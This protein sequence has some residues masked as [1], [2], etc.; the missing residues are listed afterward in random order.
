MIETDGLCKVYASRTE[1]RV[2]YKYILPSLSTVHQTSNPLLLGIRSGGDDDLTAWR[3]IMEF[4]QSW[5]TKS[6]VKITEIFVSMKKSNK[7]RLHIDVDSRLQEKMVS[8]DSMLTS[9]V[10]RK[11]IRNRFLWNLNFNFWSKRDQRIYKVVL[12]QNWTRSSK[13][14]PEFDQVWRMIVYFRISIQ[15]RSNFTIKLTEDVVRNS[16]T[17]FRR[18]NQVGIW[19]IHSFIRNWRR[20]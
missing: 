9:N 6:V 7:N 17:R 13:T 4:I 10:N 12:G 8:Y 18:R 19:S 2:L 3:K 15:F 16:S 11:W 1:I 20:N 5:Q 14:Q